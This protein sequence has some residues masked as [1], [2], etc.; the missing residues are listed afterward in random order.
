MDHLFLIVL[1]IRLSSLC[2]L[3][4]NND[5]HH[6]QDFALLVW[7]DQNSYLFSYRYALC[8]WLP[9]CNLMGGKFESEGARV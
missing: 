4:N 6:V 1:G 3:L 2:S 8:F 7:C 9:D 5:S